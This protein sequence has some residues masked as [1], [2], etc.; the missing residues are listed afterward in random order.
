MAGIGFRLHKLVE[1]DTYMQAAAAYLSSAVITSGPWL[2]SLVSLALLGSVRLAFLDGG[3]RGLL[4]ATITYAFGASLVVTGGVQMIVTRYL[5]DRLYVDDRAAI[6]P[7]CNAVLLLPLPLLLLSGPFLA[8]GPF[9]WRYRLLAVTLFVTL[10]LSWLL[11]AFLSATR[12]FANIVMIVVL[13]HGLSLGGALLFGNVYGLTGSLAGYT[14]GQVISTALLAMHVYHEFAPSERIN[15]DFLGYGREYWDLLLF[16]MLYAA[17]IWVDNV[18]Y[19]RAPGGIV[20]G[21]FYRANPAYDTMKLVAYLSTIPASAMFLVHIETRFFRHYKAFFGSVTGKGTLT[22]ITAHKE[23]MI[24]AVRTGL[25]N[26]CTLQLIV[27]GALMLFA[28]EIV[29]FVGLPPERVA[30]FRVDLLAANSQFLMLTTLL[31][32]LYL[33]ERRIAMWIVALFVVGN[34]AITQFTVM[35]GRLFDGAGYLIA[36]SVGALAALVLLRDRLKRL[37]YLTF[38]LQPLAGAR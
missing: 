19:W 3:D 1:G 2:S 28:P 34:L 16:G 33:D 11:S 20:I 38:M 26:V 21:G 37:E 25:A 27:I 24:Q 9:D 29:A 36:A 30:L 8:F 17:G 31:L 23:G 10:S 5:A 7:T 12:Y 32:L 6:A 35:S 4:I 18:L 13:G 14:L 15:P 22:H